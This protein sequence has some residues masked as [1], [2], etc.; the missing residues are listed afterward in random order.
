MR[1]SA[2][3]WSCWHHKNQKN[4]RVM[5]GYLF[6]A[7]SCD[8]MYHMQE[9][10]SDLELFYRLFT[11]LFCHLFL[12]LGL[13]THLNQVW[14]YCYLYQSDLRPF[15]CQSEF[16][17]FLG[18]LASFLTTRLI[19][20]FGRQSWRTLWSLRKTVASHRNIIISFQSITSCFDSA[21]LSSTGSE[22][23][24]NIT[25]I[26]E[27]FREKR[28]YVR[29]FLKTKRK[30]TKTMMQRCF[31]CQNKSVCQKLARSYKK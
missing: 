26:I 9:S 7:R 1:K 15:R 8:T 22:D 25:R 21:G 6:S 16:H 20:M 29:Y 23:V 13:N 5:H 18:L 12:A 14:N 30:S 28:A 11:E 3:I 10:K 2:F 31:S 27:G 19:L 4:M 17:F 24:T